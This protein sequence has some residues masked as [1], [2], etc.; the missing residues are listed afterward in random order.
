MKIM[1]LYSLLALLLLS[2]CSSDSVGTTTVNAGKEVISSV[3]EQTKDEPTQ[4]WS[5]AGAFLVVIG[6]FALAFMGVQRGVPLIAA[7][8]ICG[9]IPFIIYS[10]WFNWAAGIAITISLG[11][12]VWWV[13][14]KL[15]DSIDDN[16]PPAKS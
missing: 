4:I 12:G 14:D 10:G 2:G 3:V 7:G 6:G 11:M 5:I 15:K 8:A 9:I 13:Y 1:A 16:E